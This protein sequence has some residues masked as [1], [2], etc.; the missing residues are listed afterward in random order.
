MA[1]KGQKKRLA[2]DTNFLLDLARTEL[3]A[4]DFKDLLRRLGSQLLIPTMVN[5]RMLKPL[6]ESGSKSR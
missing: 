1:A 5:N 4:E 3:F 6:L 2:L